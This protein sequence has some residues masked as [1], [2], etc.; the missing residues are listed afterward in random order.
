VKAGLQTA[1]GSLAVD[2]PEGLTVT[3]TTTR[4]L[5]EALHILG[6]QKASLHR[7]VQLSL[8]ELKHLG[9][10]EAR[11]G[12]AQ[13]GGGMRLG[14]LDLALAEH[15]L[16]VGPMSPRARLLTLSEFLEG[17]DAGLRAIPGG[18]LEPLCLAVTAV[19]PDGRIYHSHPS[20]RSAAGPDLVALLLGGEGRLALITEAVVRCFPVPATRRAQVFSFPSADA[21][22]AATLAALSDGV[23]FEAVRIE[24]RAERAQVEFNCL[25]NSDAV[26]RDFNTLSRRAF[27]VGGRASG[28]LSGEF[29]VGPSA[30]PEW[31][32]RE[33]NWDSIR[34]AVRAQRPLELHRLSLGTAIVRGEADGLSLERSG[35]WPEPAA[36][37]AKAIDVRA[38]LG[39]AP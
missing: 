34:E 7:D 13:A 37:L 14:A 3:P 31:D 2:R 4:Q 11:G 20:P 39:G 9:R 18:R 25:G 26:D 1:L 36:A 29:P 8:A 24:T 21:F 22:V 15:G 16:S 5:T 19:L 35:A 38:V 32:E 27:D 30:G 6:S 17:P 28:K 12:T 33:A 23:W 10:V